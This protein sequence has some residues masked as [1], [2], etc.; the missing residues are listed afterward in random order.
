[1]L[2]KWL[3]H[4][5]GTPRRRRRRWDRP[6]RAPWHGDGPAQLRRRSPLPRSSGWLGSW[7]GEP[8]IGGLGPKPTTSAS[9]SPVPPPAPS[10]ST[11]PR[12]TPERCS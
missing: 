6:R 5:R 7:L 1:V 2:G 9:T 11:T 8:V 4:R 12:G 3:A 10:G